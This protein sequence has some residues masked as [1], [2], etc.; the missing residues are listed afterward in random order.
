LKLDFFY[1]DTPPYWEDEKIICLIGKIICLIV[2]LKMAETI[3]SD[4]KL[5]EEG[6]Y[7]EPQWLKPLIKETKLELLIND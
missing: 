5:E 1:G 6:T 7:S 2:S 4:C 3:T